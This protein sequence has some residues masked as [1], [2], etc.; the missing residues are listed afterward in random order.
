MPPTPRPELELC[1]WTVERA[2]LVELIH[3]AAETGYAAITVTPF[4]Y[5]AA[6]S[7]GYTDHDLRGL[8]TDAGIRVTYIDGL[9]SS[10]PGT[11]APETVSAR[12][13]LALELTEDEVFQAA[14]GLEAQSINLAHFCGRPMPFEILRDSVSE[15]AVRASERGLRVL[16]EFLPGTGIPDLAFASRIVAEVGP[17]WTGVMLDTLHFARSGGVPSQLTAGVLELI[18]GIQVSDTT[19][20]MLSGQYAPMT[21][22]LLPGQ[23]DLPLKDILTAVVDA[24]PQMP[25]GVE[26]FSET[27]RELELNEAARLGAT[28]IRDLLR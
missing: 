25:V 9:A 4:L 20:S 14:V 27:L 26:V 23:G 12:F 11:P 28:S 15:L 21:G 1:C 3:L 8:L 13:A 2:S 19:E 6:R 22:R 10:L 16:I 17:T 24:H 5:A 18:G 7:A